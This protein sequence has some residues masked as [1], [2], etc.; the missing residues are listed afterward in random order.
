M[1]EITQPKQENWWD[2]F[3]APRAKCGEVTSDELYQMFD[4]MDIK[5]EL[6]PF[7]LVDVRRADWEGGTIKTSINLPAQSFYQTRKTLLDLC[8]RAGIQKVIF[9]CG[10]SNGR[11]PRCANWMQDYID[12]V[13]KFGHKTKLQVLV[14]KG[15]IKSWVKDFEGSMMDGFEEKYWEQFK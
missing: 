9:Y 4:D 12:D 6:R 1:A 14:L 11:G 15:G 2:A 10:A 13:A 3:P 5:P 8:E 7:L